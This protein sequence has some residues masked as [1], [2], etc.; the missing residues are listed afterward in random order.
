[1]TRFRSGGRWAVRRR[2]RRG[3]EPGRGRF[4]RTHPARSAARGQLVFDSEPPR[5]PA[6]LRQL[7][8]AVFVLIDIALALVGQPAVAAFLLNQRTEPHAPPSQ[9]PGHRSARPSACRGVRR[10]VGS[11]V[12]GSRRIGAWTRGPDGHLGATSA[13]CARC[14]WWQ[15]AHDPV[16]DRPPG[17]QRR[18]EDPRAWRAAPGAACPA[19]VLGSRTA[20][21]IAYV[22][23]R[24][25][26]LSAVP[27]SVRGSKTG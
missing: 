17:A 25:E 27:P 10:R 2:R 14:A 13:R 3:A 12:W 9:D 23:P 4:A 6:W 19:R 1:V 11:R 22:I 26:R 21:S 18:R 24:A 7:L 8:R 5:N 15:S 20:A 16:A